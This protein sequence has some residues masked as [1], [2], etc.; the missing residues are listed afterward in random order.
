[1]AYLNKE[2]K[3][4]REENYDAFIKQLALNEESAGKYLSFKPN[5]TLTKNGDEYTMKI[6]AG[7]F[8]KDVTFKVGVPFQESLSNGLTPTSTVTAN[9]DTF[10][11]VQ[12]FGDKGSLTFIREFT[13]NSLK[14]TIKSSKWDGVA[15]RYYVAA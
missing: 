2:F 13:A 11:Q 9:G 14:V 4:D 15:Y 6:S 1:M 5:L 8:K 10:T 7:D 3:F 12:D